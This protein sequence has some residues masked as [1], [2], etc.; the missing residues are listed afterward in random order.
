M[1][2]HPVTAVDSDAT[3]LA[4]LSNWITGLDQKNRAPLGPVEII[5]ADLE[6][7]PWPLNGRQF[8]AVIVVNY[9]WRP[10]LP[11]IISAVDNG[12]LLIYETFASG[13][14]VF[15]RPRNPDYLLNEGE[16]AS[17]VTTDFEVIAHQ[18][19]LVGIPAYAAISRIAAKKTASPLAPG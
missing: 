5:N 16:L 14:E 2:G 1:Q 4:A 11:K 3:A 12:G 8:D 19:G 9:L 7:G 18:H 13:N 17:A 15:G 10:L 6:N